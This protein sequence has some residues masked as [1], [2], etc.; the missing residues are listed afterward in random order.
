MASL[1]GPDIITN[2]LVLSLDAANNKS[3]PG[4][5]TTWFDISGNNNHVTLYNSVSYSNSVLSGDGVNSY[6]RTTNTL[7]L[8]GLSAITI[9]C[10][11]KTPST[12][13]A[14]MLYEHTSNWNTNNTYGSTSY[15]GFGL[16]PNSNGGSN[17]ANLNHYQLRGNL[18]YSGTN[19]TTPD[20][21]KFQF[22]TTT[23]DF[24]QSTEETVSYV[25]GNR[26]TS[27]F[28]YTGNNTQTFV[29]DYFYLWSRGGTGTY[30]N[31]S[32][33]LIQI[34]NRSFNILEIQQNY[35]ATKARF[36]L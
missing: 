25:N 3:Y 14:G 31:A 10:V 35:N 23:H 5:G 12:A 13:T 21:T 19:A 22:Y 16:S 2:G 24:S 26:I 36:N 18:G 7:D 4:S 32:V 8:T 29:N 9:F 17:T 1:G 6:G 33:S 20:I 11:F 34:Y 28:I 30:L 15:G 27:T